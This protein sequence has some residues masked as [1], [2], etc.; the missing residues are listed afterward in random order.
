[1]SMSATPGRVR[2]GCLLA[3]ACAAPAAQAGD[4][5]WTSAASGNYATAAAWS[6]AGGRPGGRGGVIPGGGA[7]PR[8]VAGLRGGGRAG[9]REEATEPDAPGSR[10]H[11]HP[12]SRSVGAGGTVR[13]RSSAR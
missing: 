4:Y 8:V 1:M 7:G 10:G 5:T 3:L 11:A 13:V 9:Q 2:F 12:L 6:P